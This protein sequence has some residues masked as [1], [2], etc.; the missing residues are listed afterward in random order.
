MSTE[1]AYPTTYEQTTTTQQAAS[2]PIGPQPA[3]AQSQDGILKI[4]EIVLCI[5][6][7]ICASIEWWF[8]CC[9]G[10][11]WVQF[12]ACSAMITTLVI[13]ILHFLNLVPRMP[14]GGYWSM[15]RFVYYCVY[16]VLFAIAGIVAAVKAP[17]YPSIGAAAFF[18]FAALVVYGVDAFFMYRGWKM[19]QHP[20]TGGAGTTTTTTT[21]IETHSQY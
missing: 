9:G 4:V 6:V 2:P 16:V 3:Y 15:I 12:V 5:I 1:A 11:G 8:V 21:T 13:F 20:H 18:T 10:G 17:G 7:L 19:V 14:F